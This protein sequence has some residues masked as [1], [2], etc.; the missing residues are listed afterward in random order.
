MKKFMNQIE[1]VTI[2]LTKV[3]AA[4]F[5]LRKWSRE[6]YTK[7]VTIFIDECKVD[8][9]F[10]PDDYSLGN[11][12]R[13]W[14]MNSQYKLTFEYPSLTLITGLKN[15]DSA[16]GEEAAKEIFRIYEEATNKLIFFA[17][18]KL[19]L[20]SI[21]DGLK[22]RFD[23][24]FYNDGLLNDRKVV[25][26]I[27][28]S[29]PKVF[30]L[31]R[32][33]VKGK[34]ITQFQAKNLLTPEKWGKLDQY[35]L[36]KPNTMSEVEELVKI[37]AK[38]MWGENR[39]PVVETMALLEVIVRNKAHTELIKKGLSKKKLKESE[40]DIG[41]SVLLNTVLPLIMTKKENETHKEVISS[42][43]TLRRIRNDIMHNNLKESEIDHDQVLKCIDS[44]IKLAQIISR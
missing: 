8:I 29:E 9:T 10:L 4:G 25:Y 40:S 36:S 22:T 28:A 3:S 30:T 18:F 23:E 24:L 15:P 20:H 14:V 6:D 21:L 13:F 39:I 1:K 38:A 43:N 12:D 44:A 5:M 26:C 35:T 7:S 41:M 31:Q 2:L 37:K 17:R 33:K 32:K 11:N 27:G 16:A 34:I 42:V 19:N